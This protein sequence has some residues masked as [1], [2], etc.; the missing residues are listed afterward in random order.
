MGTKYIPDL[1]ADNIQVTGTLS[2]G[3]FNLPESVSLTGN[4]DASGTVTTGSIGGSADVR[5][6]SNED[7]AANVRL[8]AA[9]GT[10]ETPADTVA[11]MVGRIEAFGRKDDAPSPAG[12]ITFR[13]TPAL[14]TQV[15]IANG[16]DDIGLRLAYDGTTQ[17][18]GHSVTIE[19]VGTSPKGA[20]LLTG[21]EVL[22]GASGEK[23]GFFGE[24][25]IT[26]PAITGWDEK[27]DSQKIDALKDALVALGLIATDE[28]EGS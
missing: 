21:E 28:E 11:E 4:L 9:R 19:A 17:I 20:L 18:Y 22:V 3:V 8:Y 5:N 10:Q 12:S 6:Y 27:T 7:P 26:K 24:V 13:H 25:A 1:V 16:A 15:E 14:A 2:A 23:V